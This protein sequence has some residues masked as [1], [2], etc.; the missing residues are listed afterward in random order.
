VF[1]YVLEFMIAKKLVTH[2]SNLEL[3]NFLLWR[4][5]QQK[6]QDFQTSII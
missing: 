1:S 4:S 2:I 6:Y 5:L 3:V